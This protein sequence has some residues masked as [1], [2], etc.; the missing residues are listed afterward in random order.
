MLCQ[1][2][3]IRESETAANTSVCGADTLRVVAPESTITDR[4]REV[5]GLRGW[6]AAELNRRAGLSSPTHVSMILARGAGSRT[7]GEVLSKIAAAAGVRAH[8]LLTGEGPR[9]IEAPEASDDPKMQ[10]RPGF[11]GALA[12]A[13]V[14]RPQY[15]EYV[16][17]AVAHVDPLMIVPMTPA[18]LADLADVIVKYL[19]PPTE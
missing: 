12:G 11:R 9:D 14:L 5:M 8:W 1:Y 15:G 16:W 2:E 18:L 10:G 6:S 17:N 7:S 3:R 13:K 4:I 19:P